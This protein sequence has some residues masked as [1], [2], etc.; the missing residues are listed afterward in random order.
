MELIAK[1]AEA[2][3]YK[4]DKIVVKVRDFKS[5]RLKELDNKLI[6]E[7]T[8]I[9]ARLL[10]KLK[11]LVPNILNVEENVIEME[12]LEGNVLK[13]VITPTLCEEAGKVVKIMHDRN[14]VHGDL[15]TSNIIFNNKIFLID[16]GLAKHSL[17]LEDKAVDLHLFKQ[18]LI[19]KHHNIFEDCWKNFIK[20]YNISNDL[21]VRLEQVE[22]RGRNKLK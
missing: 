22:S 4:K 17:R 20:G 6:S 15:T 3:I 2:S 14:V 10:K 7:R 5:Y 13:E 8:K 16:F 18:S 1:G 21:L 11:G 9:E 12:F 19:S